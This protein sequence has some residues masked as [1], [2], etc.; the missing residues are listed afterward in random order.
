MGFNSVSDSQESW[1]FDEWHPGLAFCVPFVSIEQ[2]G[3]LGFF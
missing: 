2:F 3:V 1:A